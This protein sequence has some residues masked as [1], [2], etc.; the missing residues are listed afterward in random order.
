MKKGGTKLDFTSQLKQMFSAKKPPS[1]QTSVQT[2]DD[3]CIDIGKSQIHLQDSVSVLMKII[4]DKLN[5]Q[6]DAIEEI[7]NKV[8]NN[9]NENIKLKMIIALND[10]QNIILSNEQLKTMNQL[11]T[12]LG[13]AEYKDFEKEI[14]NKVVVNRIKKFMAYFELMIPIFGAIIS[15]IFSSVKALDS[16]FLNV[17]GKVLNKLGNQNTEKILEYAYTNGFFSGDGTYNNITHNVLCLLVNLKF[18]K[19]K[20]E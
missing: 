9:E 18:S 5:S 19:I 2:T 4:Q 16:R 20:N 3:C 11:K 12:D 14:S 1:V 13:D 17:F 10:D 8:K 6:N 7:N 15:I